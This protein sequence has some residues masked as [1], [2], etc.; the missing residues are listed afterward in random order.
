MVSEKLVL[1]GPHRQLQGAQGTHHWALVLDLRKC[2]S[3]GT[4]TRGNKRWPF[5]TCLKGASNMPCFSDAM[6]KLP[7]SKQAQN[8]P[9]QQKGCWTR[10][11]ICCDCAPQVSYNFTFQ[12]KPLVDS[13]LVPLKPFSSTG[14]RVHE[15]GK[16]HPWELMNLLR[17]S[18]VSLPTMDVV[19][20][21]STLAYP[22]GTVVSQTS[23]Q[24]CRWRKRCR[25]GVQPWW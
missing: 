11:H 19:Q 24:S 1:A 5:E 6:V 17:L 4:W 12:R 15:T 21:M 14:G 16:G 23:S 10:D 2:S 3:G 8:S 22:S 20:P 13:T 18:A 7:K 9:R 25:K